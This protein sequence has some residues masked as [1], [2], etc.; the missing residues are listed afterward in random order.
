MGDRPSGR[1][2]R[3]HADF[4]FRRRDR[5][6]QPQR[7]PHLLH[8]RRRRAANRRFDS[9]ASTAK[10]AEPWTPPPPTAPAGAVP[11]TST[12]YLLFLTIFAAQMF[13]GQGNPISPVV[14]DSERCST[15]SILI[16]FLTSLS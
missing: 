6:E 10:P 7:G 2:C 1:R 4:P 16:F 3:L 8:R 5:S 12:D 11:P 14:M 9:D 13:L 15:T